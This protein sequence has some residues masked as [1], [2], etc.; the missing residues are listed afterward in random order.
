MNH[1]LMLILLIS[2]SHFKG[3]SPETPAWV[4]GIREGSESLKV[5]N[6]NK[7][8]YRRILKA[9]DE[10][11]QSVCTKVLD[12]AARDIQTEFLIDTKIPYTLEYLHYDEEYEDCSVTL[13]ISSQMS[14]RLIEIKEIKKNHDEI[15]SDLEDKWREARKEKESIER[16]NHELEAYIRQNQHLLQKYND[17]LSSLNKAWAMLKDRKERASESAL[18]GLSKKEFQR[19]VRHDVTISFST[20]SKCWDAFKSAHLSYHGTTTV[21]WSGSDQAFV[22]GYCD[23]AT[24]SCF[25]RNP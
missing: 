19:L 3:K 20:S 2:C 12:L 13:S 25:T 11:Q 16:R 9:D 22:R 14:S 23:T 15:V 8:F 7:V 1:L 24:K 10:N 17:H 5:I 6:G 21:C 18:T 4:N